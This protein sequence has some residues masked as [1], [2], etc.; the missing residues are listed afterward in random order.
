[1]R[2]EL[3]VKIASDT[4]SFDLG[5]L[6]RGARVGQEGT[7]YNKNGYLNTLGNPGKHQLRRLLD[8]ITC[9]CTEFVAYRVLLFN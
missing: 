9:T 7:K 3:E 5:E 6:V 4:F 1:M 8:G 2:S